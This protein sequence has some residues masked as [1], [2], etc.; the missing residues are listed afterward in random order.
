V[1][2]A[3]ALA[4]SGRG[5]LAAAQYLT[6]ADAVAPAEATDLRLCAARQLLYS[7]NIDDGLKVLDQV[8]RMVGMK[9]PGSGWRSVASWLLLR[10]RVRAR[11]GLCGDRY[12]QRDARSVPPELANQL[13]VCWTI[14]TGP[15]LVESLRGAAFHSRHL[16]LAL[17]SGQPHLVAKSLCWETAWSASA[18]THRARRTERLLRVADAHVDRLDDPYCQGIRLLTHGAAAYL[19]LRWGDALGIL[20]RA[21]RHFRT[22]CTGVTWELDTTQTFA[23]WSLIYLGQL[24]ELRRRFAPLLLE[25]RDRSDLYLQ[26]NL[27]TFT[28]AVVHA[29]QDDPQAARDELARITEKWSHAGFHVQHHNVLQARAVLDLYEGKGRAAWD[30]LSAHRTAYRRSLLIHSQHPRVDFLQWHARAALA[31]AAEADDPA[32]FLRAAGRSA[33]RLAREG[34]PCPVAHAEFLRAGIAYLYGKSESAVRHLRAAALGYDAAGMHLCA[35]AV[36]RRLGQL[37]GG[38]EGQKLARDASASME[39]EGIV[40]PGRITAVYT[41]GFPDGD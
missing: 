21:T 26:M 35:A 12:R 17:R 34:A 23:L 29:A 40:H 13:Q 20:D 33:R 7:G 5:A 3:E 39:R 38:E 32:M 1:R 15:G 2:L 36:R 28:M 4:N 11:L 16:L 6:M 22:H 30:Y 14:A 31:V 37:T 24:A 25:A 9:L 18:G 8:L 10:L 19:E 41:P 27:S